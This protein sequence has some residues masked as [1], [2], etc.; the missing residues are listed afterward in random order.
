MKRIILILCALSLAACKEDKNADDSVV[1]PIVPPATIAQIQSAGCSVHTS[2]KKINIH[3]ADNT[4]ADINLPGTAPSPYYIKTATNQEFPNLIYM[5]GTNYFNMSTGHMVAFN[6]SGTLNGVKRVYFEVSNCGGHMY[7]DYAVGGNF[8]FANQVYPNQ[9]GAPGFV[10]FN[11]GAS[12]TSTATLSY[13]QD[14]VCVNQAIAARAGLAELTSVPMDQG[15]PT[16]LDMPL[17]LMLA[18]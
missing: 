6:S 12:L 4:E 14:S 3:C 18:Q 2:A 11:F 9:S 15:I 5:D 8:H 17:T 16:Q 7:A 10:A 13:Y 1:V